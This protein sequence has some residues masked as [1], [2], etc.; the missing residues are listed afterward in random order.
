[1]S[2]SGKPSVE[3]TGTGRS[4]RVIYREAGG[5]LTFH[6]EIGG[7]DAI[8]IIQTG[9]REAWNAQYRWAAGRR[10][11]I[12]RFVAAET[13]RQKAP[14][15]RVEID[16]KAG[17]I[18]LR[19]VSPSRAA[20]GPSDAAWY[21]R[22]RNLR[23][24]LALTVLAAALVFAGFMWLKNTFLSIDPGKGTPIGLSVR[25]ETHIATLIQTLEPYTPSLNRDHGKDRYAISLFLVPLDG[26]EPRH[27]PIVG[28]LA[29]NQFALAK[30]LGSDGRSLWFDV[31]GLARL[32]LSNYA[33]ERTDGPAPRD[34]QGGH[35]TPFPPRPDAFLSAGFLTA[36]DVWLGLHSFA[37][38]ERDFKPQKFVRRVVPAGETR[39]MRRFHRAELE[40]D[41]SG[42]YN[43]I[44]SIARIGEAEYLNAAF[45]RIDDQSEPLRL[46]DP[47]GAL[48]LYTSAPGLKGTA[49]IARVDTEGAVVWQVDTGIDRFNLTQI[50]PGADSMA[51]V[52]TRPREEGKVPE[53]LLVIV[54]NSSGSATTHSLWR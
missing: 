47:D 49:M 41:S 27:I 35:S 29:P 12:L 25:T 16:E 50:L 2:G 38:L 5:E 43:R 52:G 20:P 4:G 37:E 33:I 42:K 19:Q 40:P 45:L 39:E 3:I 26:S 34:L 30:I 44:L 1:M 9:T 21:Y 48:M 46:A 14:G 54:Q 28:D 23:V 7:R 32:D 6:W 51:F 22:L 53:P 36:P 10:S 13:A 31:S 18:V 15:A 24:R 17:D 8:A 11:E